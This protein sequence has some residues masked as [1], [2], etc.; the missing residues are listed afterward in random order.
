MSF[1]KTCILLSVCTAS[2]FAQEAA[3]QEAQAPAPQATQQ[4]AAM[5]PRKLSLLD[6]KK[7]ALKDN[8][9][10]QKT[11]AR[12]QAAYAR[13]LQAKAAFAPSINLYADS[14]RTINASKGDR[15]GVHTDAYSRH[16]IG[17]AASYVLY[18]GHADTFRVIA[19][20]LGEKIAELNHTDAQRKL[21]LSVTTAYYDAL[22][23]RQNVIIAVDDFKYNKKLQ[24]NAEKKLKHGTGTRSDVLNFQIQAQNADASRQLAERNFKVAVL[25]LGELLGVNPSQI[26]ADIELDEVEN[27][28]QAPDI[29]P[30]EKLLTSAIENRPD[31]QAANVAIS[32]QQAVENQYRGANLPTISANANY[33]FSKRDNTH[34]FRNDYEDASIGISMNWNILDG[35]ETRARVAEAYAQRLEYEASRQSL[36]QSIK[37]DL[38]N[39]IYTIDYAKS[40]AALKDE[41]QKLA[42]QARDLV[43]KEYD[44]GRVTATR[45]NEA[46]TDLTSAQGDYAKAVINYWLNRENLE[47]ATGS[48][49]KVK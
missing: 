10:L 39:R 15:H 7:I 47:A 35:H 43:Q 17:L 16:D 34:Y 21:L 12:L 48:I 5:L 49:L 6:A 9:D 42:M 27:Y 41:T 33:G 31:L 36:L 20:E 18:N 30:Y 23:E 1:K 13:V 38:Q 29:E 8:P 11:I 26:P 14:N 19:Q 44:T 2:I 45:L 37:H 32:Q 28:L 3:T 22:L 46:Q 40:I 24:E 25:A 4:Q